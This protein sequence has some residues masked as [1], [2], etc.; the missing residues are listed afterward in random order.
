MAELSVQLTADIRTLLRDLQKSEDA[1]ENLGVTAKQV[2]ALVNRFGS[3]TRKAGKATANA[4]P[5]LLEFNRVIQDAPFGIQGVANNIQ[6][7]TQNFGTLS[8]SAGGPIQALKLL[9]GSFA[10]PAGILFVVSAATSLLVAFGDELFKSKD[11]AEEL[12]KELERINDSFGSELR[13]SKAIEESLEL[14]GISTTGILNSRKDLLRVQIQNLQGLINEQQELLNI[15]KI[16]NA[17]VDNLEI[18]TQTAEKLFT[19][20]K[21][22]ARLSFEVFSSAAVKAFENVLNIEIDRSKFAAA[23]VEDRLKEEKLQN[24][25]KDLKAQ[26]LELENSILKINEEQRKSVQSLVNSTIPSNL[27]QIFGNQQQQGPT[28]NPFAN[29]IELAI[30]NAAGVIDQAPNL[31][32]P[33]LSNIEQRFA[34]FQSRLEQSSLNLAPA[35]SNGFAQLGQALAQGGDLFGSVGQAIL[36]TLGSIITQ[37]GQATI[38]SGIAAISLKNLF[39]NPAAA[40]AAGGALVALGSALSSARSSVSGIGGGGSI[41]GQG[42][43]TGFTGS[44]SF[45]GSNVSATQEVRFVLKGEDLFGALR[46][47]SERNGRIGGSIVL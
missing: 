44:N 23:S 1:L 41:A 24:K 15:Q 35:I 8:R 19:V 16:E 2:D 14:Q 43:G 7:L 45:N 39:S 33:G 26:Q 18:L 13:L 30:K 5:T 27:D 21:N 31:I 9:A 6:Q 17:R 37:L 4:T 42:T 3:S 36:Q 28:G 12:Q 46:N 34:D 38:A 32:S 22:I 40:I 10:G 47:V 11:N 29:Q 20:T 25:L